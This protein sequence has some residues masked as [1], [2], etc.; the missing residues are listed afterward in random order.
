VG[1]FDRAMLLAGVLAAAI[2]AASTIKHDYSALK[3]TVTD[4][5][6]MFAG[7][8]SFFVSQYPRAVLAVLTG[9]VAFI[10]AVIATLIHGTG[11]QS[12]GRQSFSIQRYPCLR[13]NAFRLSGGGISFQRIKAQRRCFIR[14]SWL[15]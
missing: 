3:L 5:P 11:R 9:T 10:L 7:T 13:C 14:P 2:T 1:D 8:A 6:L 12:L 4:V 15:R